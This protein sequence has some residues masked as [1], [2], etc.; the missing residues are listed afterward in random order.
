M[1]CVASSGR[2]ANCFGLIHGFGFASVLAYL[3][4]LQ[5]ALVGFNLHV[6]A[7]QMAIV[8]AFVP[9]AFW[10]R[11]TAFYRK[12]VLTWGSLGVAVIAAWRF[13]QR[14]LDIRGG[15]THCQAETSTD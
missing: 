3:G 2:A 13:V 12:G 1:H 10:P 14:G 4:L 11:G 15:L 8:I 9:L 7:G 6:E 5:E